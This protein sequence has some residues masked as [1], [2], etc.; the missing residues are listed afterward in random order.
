MLAA[1]HRDA[2]GLASCRVRLQRAADAGSEAAPTAL[3]WAAGL[4]A[5]SAGDAQRARTE[6]QACLDQ[7]SRLG[8]SHAQR[9]IVDRTL[10]ALRLPHALEGECQ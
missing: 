3:H 2:Q 5:L 4:E 6:L 7:A 1:A 10:A 8:G 9:T